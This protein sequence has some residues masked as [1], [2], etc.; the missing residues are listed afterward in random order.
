MMIKNPAM[1]GKKARANFLSP[2]NDSIRYESRKPTI[3]ST[4]VLSLEDERVSALRANTAN[5]ATRTRKTK[6]VIVVFEIG[7]YT[8][9][10][11]NFGT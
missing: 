11:C 2:P 8:D 5:T 4:Q 1:S 7:P 10:H 3:L 6:E 9:S